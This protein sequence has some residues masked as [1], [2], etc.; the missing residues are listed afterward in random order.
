[1][2]ISRFELHR[3]VD[4]TGVSGTG[5]VAEGLR[6]SDGTCAMRWK[7]EHTS[8]A[9]YRS[10]IDV[11]KIHGHDGK[12]RVVMVGDAWERGRRD[13]Y[14]DRCENVL[15]ASVMPKP[16]TTS[17]PVHETDRWRAPEYLSADDWPAYRAGYEHC[18][19]EL[20]PG[21]RTP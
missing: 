4:E 14:Q 7:T 6:F 19:T 17:L 16:T 12:T 15:G 2:A 13:C 11:Q 8:T 1:M 18:L 5:V 3:D 21:W 9:V 20:W 10:L